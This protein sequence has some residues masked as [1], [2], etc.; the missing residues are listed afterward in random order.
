MFPLL[1]A[2]EISRASKAAPP[3][4]DLVF[5]GSPLQWTLRKPVAQLAY[6][7]LRGVR[8]PS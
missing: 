2:R 4:S 5:P 3:E 6:P 8:P 1:L 7:V